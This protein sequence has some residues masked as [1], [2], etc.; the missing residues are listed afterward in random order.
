[1]A[2]LAALN[3]GRLAIPAI[4]LFTAVGMLVLA[5]VSLRWLMRAFISVAAKVAAL[6]PTLLATRRY[7]RPEKPT[8]SGWFGS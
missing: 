4:A 1:M 3:T 6:R 5:F 8:H 2:T 7:R